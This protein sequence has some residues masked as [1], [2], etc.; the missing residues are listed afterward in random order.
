MLANIVY[1][2]EPRP[3]HPAGHLL[4]SLAPVMESWCCQVVASGADVVIQ[5]LRRSKEEG[6]TPVVGVLGAVFLQAGHP[7]LHQGPELARVEM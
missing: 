5:V 1:T 7:P 6:P 4:A 2:S 3:M